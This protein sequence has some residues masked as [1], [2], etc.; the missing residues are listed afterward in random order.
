MTLRMNYES[1]R[2]VG[3]VHAR[4]AWR[5]AAIAAAIVGAIAGVISALSTGVLSIGGPGSTGVPG[6]VVVL[7]V[8]LAALGAS[9]VVAGIV[10]LRRRRDH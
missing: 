4:E 8:V 9:F 3:A 5:A 10:P 6:E 1:G 7:F 2:P